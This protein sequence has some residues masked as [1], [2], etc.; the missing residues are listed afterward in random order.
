[1]ATYSCPMHPDVTSQRP[2][3][4]SK[5]GMRLEQSEGSSATTERQRTSRNE[6]MK[7]KDNTK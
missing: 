6:P 5:C 4:C 7:D 3:S 2:G 1:M